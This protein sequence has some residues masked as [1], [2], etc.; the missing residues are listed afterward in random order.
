MTASYNNYPS[1]LMIRYS[2]DDAKPFYSSTILHGISTVIDG[3]H[4][5]PPHATEL[6]QHEGSNSQS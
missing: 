6:T 2:G 1:E 4:A 3:R 5:R